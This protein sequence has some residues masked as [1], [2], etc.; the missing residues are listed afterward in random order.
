MLY[1][2]AYLT[3]GYD[4]LF[5][6]GRLLFTG[7][8][9]GEDSLMSLATIGAFVIGEYMEGVLVMLLYQIGELFQSYAVGESRNSIAALMDLRPDYANVRK[10]GV[11]VRVDPENVLP[12]EEIFIKPGEKVP[13]D[14]RVV[15]GGTFIDSS[16]LTGES[17][18]SEALVGSEVLSG[19]VN[20]NAPI[21]IKVSR[22]FTESAAARI[23]D[24]VENVGARKSKSEDFI[25]KFAR[26]YTPGVVGAAV[27]LAFL[28]SLLIPGASFISWFRRALIF[29]VVSCPCALVISVPLSYFGGLGGAS[30]RG[31]LIKGSNYLEAFSGAKTVVFDKTGTLTK[32]VFRVSEVQPIG[33]SGE[34][35]LEYT[36]LAE[37]YSDHPISA[38]LKQA[39]GKMADE[40]AILDFEE[41]PGMGVVTSVHGKRVASGNEKLM[42]KEHVVPAEVQDAGSVVH[43]AID[44]VYAGY[45][46]IRDEVK[47]GAAEAIVVLRQNGIRRIVMMTG[48]SARAAKH[49]ADELGIEEM[50]SELLP[51]DKVN[52]VEKLVTEQPKGGKLVFVG[53]GIN[54]APVLRRADIGV[55]M[56]RAGRDAAIEAADIVLM[57]DDPAELVKA[58]RLSRQTSRIVRQN[59]VL[60]LGVKGTVLT[61][62]V[63]GVA[64]MSQA[65]FA[66]V[67]VMILAVI[68][69]TRMLRPGKL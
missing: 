48:D 51:V 56:G 43:V 3:A 17:V 19:S 27:L 47:E 67:G 21:T 26:Y 14:G 33:I 39:Y 12:G 60:A 18:P 24:M 55:A 52:L 41:L 45:I 10:D 40:A 57:Q 59:I 34:E 49:V 63:L 31:I 32:G 46:C 15:E 62:S 36:A 5:K 58:I 20:L 44:E 38:S 28:P 2:A 8:S 9:L 29:L 30:K 61:L 64:T 6:A 22:P 4:V 69:A 35:L 23:L 53:D 7:F 11:L 65:V 50:Y 1:I 25:T 66:D 54:D 42:K 13:L 37:W 16:A 68:N